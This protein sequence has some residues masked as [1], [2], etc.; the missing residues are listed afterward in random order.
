MEPSDLGLHLLHW[1]D[2]SVYHMKLIEAKR[3]YQPLFSICDLISEKVPYCGTN[4]VILDQPFSHFCDN[5]FSLKLH[6]EQLKCFLYMLIGNK[7]CRP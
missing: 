6:M 5:I 7:Y 4:S 1:A 3:A 2:E